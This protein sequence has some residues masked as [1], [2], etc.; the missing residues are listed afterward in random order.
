MGP[1]RTA[2]QS[3]TA[4]LSARP[5]GFARFSLPDVLPIRRGNAINFFMDVL[6]QLEIRI[7]ELLRRLA[8]AEADSAQKGTELEAAAKEREALEA[9]KAAL[10]EALARERAWRAEALARLDALLR[11]VEAYGGVE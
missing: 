7:S 8:A 9:E 3:R 10:L 1:R 6:E 11:R 4:R 5:V 2:A